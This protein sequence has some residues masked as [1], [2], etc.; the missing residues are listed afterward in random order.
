M[1]KYF[2]NFLLLSL[3]LFG[4]L[5]AE[6]DKFFDK[7]GVSSQQNS[8]EAFDSD[9]GL[10]FTGGNGT[11]K[12]RVYDTNPI[13]I[14]MPSFSAGCGGIDYSW[15]GISFVSKEELVSTLKGIASN[16]AGYAFLLA[17]ETISPQ[18]SSA[19][20]QI[21]SWANTFNSMSLNSCEVA[22]SLVNMTWPKSQRASDY[23]CAQSGS[24][25]G[26]FDSIISARHG[27]RKDPQ[28]RDEI[29]SETSTQNPEIFLD[30]F[31]VAWSVLNKQQNIQSE[32]LKHLF[33][34]LTGTIVVQRNKNGSYERK[35]YSP[36]FK[37]SIEIL[38]NGG[39]IDGYSISKDGFNVQSSKISIPVQNA[40]KPKIFTILKEIQSKIS[41]ERQSNQVSLSEDAKKLIQSTHFPIAS[42]TILMT[43][44]NG[45]HS[46]INLEK[47]SETI[48]LEKIIQLVED[49]IET[50]IQTASALRENQID[51][52]PI[53]EYL[54]NLNHIRKELYFMNQE[55]AQKMNG[56]HQIIKYLIDLEKNMRSKE[57]EL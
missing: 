25:N 8:A 49:V 32:D 34:T 22:T 56:D 14:D 20:K 53:D 40:W 38:K 42:L 2:Y 18:V 43:A 29:F 7:L 37:E 10:H 52:K 26:M 50:S 23:I 41:N 35:V 48:A 24:K 57:R 19:M 12:N 17:T 11:F 44:Y 46:L 15:G 16:A 3:H 30:N 39:S 55:N 45:N 9:L 36:K 28:K 54:K 13:H 51:S 33:M 31:N 6:C 4:D 5:A 1:L 27:C 47:Y 21:Q